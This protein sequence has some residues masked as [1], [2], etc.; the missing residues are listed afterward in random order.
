[1]RTKGSFWSSQKGIACQL[2]AALKEAASWQL[3]APVKACSVPQ[4]HASTHKAPSMC[5]TSTF[6]SSSSRHTA[7][8]HLSTFPWRPM[9]YCSTASRSLMAIHFCSSA[10]EAKCIAAELRPPFLLP[11][12]LEAEKS[13][14]SLAPCATCALPPPPLHSCR[15][16]PPPLSPLQWLKSTERPAAACWATSSQPS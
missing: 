5:C 16:R 1:M 11:K 13:M 2:R 12:A 7:S 10:T 14:H 3:L 15:P 6:D 9:P 8:A 4:V